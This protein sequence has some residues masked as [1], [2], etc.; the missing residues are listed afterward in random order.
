MIYILFFILLVGDNIANFLNLYVFSI[1]ASLY[2]ARYFKFA[3]LKL[4]RFSYILWLSREILLS[5]I[6]I[7]RYIYKGDG[8]GYSPIIDKVNASR[9][10]DHLILYANSITLTPGTV[11]IDI[12][13]NEL[14]VHALDISMMRELKKSSVNL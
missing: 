12:D 9:H 8:P 14:T 5:A 4:I 3:N 7:T 6:N 2:I 11:T 13:G 1:L 10:K